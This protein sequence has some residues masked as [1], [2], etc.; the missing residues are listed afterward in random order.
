M[1]ARFDRF[2]DFPFY[3]LFFSF[4]I[5]PFALPI[6]Y[7]C[8]KIAAFVRETVRDKVV[9]CQS[10]RCHAVLTILLSLFETASSS[11]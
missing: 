6:V 2:E 5:F 7:Y 9:K 1:K 3:F 8:L 10:L 4:S 11:Q